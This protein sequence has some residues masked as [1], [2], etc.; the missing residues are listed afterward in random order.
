MAKRKYQ[1]KKNKKKTSSANANF[2]KFAL[3]LFILIIVL[4]YFSFRGWNSKQINDLENIST[5]VN[6]SMGPIEYASMGEGQIIL[7]SHME[8]SGADNLKLFNGLIKA[9]FRIICP[10]RP[11]YLNTPLNEDATYNYQSEIFAEL[12]HHLNIN[13]KVIVM[14]VSAGGPA[15][16]EFSKNHP[17]KTSAL[18]LI[19]AATERI[20]SISYLT[21]YIHLKE[22]PLLN[23][24]S[25]INSWI[26]FNL[27]KYQTK[28]MI[29]SLIEVSTTISHNER[30]K[31][32]DELINQTS[33][34]E[35]FLTFLKCT[36]PN[37]KRYEGLNND[38][39][40]LSTYQ[41]SDEKIKIP[42]LILHSKIDKVINLGHAKNFKLIN[43]NTEL[44]TYEG[45]G[46]AFW[47]SNDLKVIIEKTTTFIKNKV[48]NNS[49]TNAFIEN[50]LTGVTWVNKSD[51]A[52][53]QIKTDG[54]FDLDFPSVDTKKYYR[55]Q[56]SIVDDQIS[57]IYSS[58]V[59]SCTG[60]AGIY[61]IK[62]SADQMELKPLND[63]C[64]SRK[65]HFSQGWFKIN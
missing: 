8:G 36:S 32:V 65:Q 60:I 52:L 13:Q 26:V 34:K 47:L 57:F 30:S 4:A 40:N 1:S 16:I 25:D 22:I 2:I 3:L 55:G 43:P 64:N 10:S 5:I 20:D 27:A 61:K 17:D 54:S 62:I 11:G 6:T 41:I 46:H 23:K 37:S 51:G 44:Y 38:L 39:K 21:K 48:A 58:D 49:N 7:L 29:A 45:N 33:S 50:G 12:L 53:L 24:K 28:S 59:K 15:A 14:G 9:G 35:Q 56:V 42:T 19:D 63:E 31:K 18:I